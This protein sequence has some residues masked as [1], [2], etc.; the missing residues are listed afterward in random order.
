MKRRNKVEL[1][2]EW[3]RLFDTIS[4]V[5]G[6]GLNRNLSLSGNHMSQNKKDP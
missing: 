5:D 1:T 4:S 6:T 3:L 2:E